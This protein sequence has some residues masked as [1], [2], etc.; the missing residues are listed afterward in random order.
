ML[1]FWLFVFLVLLSKFSL[2]QKQK[3]IPFQVAQNYFVNNSYKQGELSS[4]KFSNALEFE[5]FIGMA[6]IQGEKGQPTIIDFT[7]QF[8]IIVIN[9]ITNVQTEL[10]PEKLILF[11]KKKLKFVYKT[12][13]GEQT[14]FMMQPFTM[15]IVDKKYK[16]FKIELETYAVL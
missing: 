1:K 6:T 3:E 12:I 14:T 10:I 9:D 15:I 8:V 13:Q 5:K 2:T 11:G 4:F 7:K 16:N